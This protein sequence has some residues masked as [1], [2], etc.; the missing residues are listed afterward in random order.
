MWK[1]P[2]SVLCA[3]AFTG[4]LTA[5]FFGGETDSATAA[6]TDSTIVV[7]TLKKVAPGVYA[8]NYPWL[9]ST[10]SPLESEFIL[11]SNGTYRLFWIQDNVAFFDIQGSWF[12][13]DSNLY[14]T[15]IKQGRAQ[16]GLFRDFKSIEDDTNAVR[17]V[18]DTSFIRREYAPVRQKPLWITYTKRN[19]PVLQNGSYR[20]V[21]TYPQDS[22]TTL[23]VHFK[24]TLDGSHYLFN[25]VEDTLESFQASSKWYQIGSFLATEDNLQRQL[26]STMA[27]PAA[28]DT[29]GGLIL[30]RLK[31]VSDTGFGLWSPETFYDTAS[32]DPYRKI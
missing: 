23:Q 15:G 12:Q 28:W 27:F 14:F 7:P 11:D 5:C 25:V 3:L 18:T 22:V 1:T 24:I 20:T 13:R 4:C 32:W 16:Y 10:N 30:T 17:D 19:F 29:L 9:D 31:T 8:A 21:K 26:D 2:S 6:K